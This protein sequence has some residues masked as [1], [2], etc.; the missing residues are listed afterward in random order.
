M[1][2]WSDSAT[3]PKRSFKYKLTLQGLG[4]ANGGFPSWVIKK[5]SRPTF[6][7]TEVA[8]SFLDKKYYFPGK[9]EWDPVQLTIAEPITPNST[10]ELYRY[11]FGAGYNVL[12]KQPVGA[13]DYST[14]GKSKAVIR[15]ATID[16]LNA[17]GQTIESWELKN[18][19][20]TNTTL[21]GLDYDTDAIMSFDM[22]LRFDWANFS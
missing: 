12:T 10:R 3:E 22:T 20:I 5:T 2:F 6:K 4:A 15:T 9:V 13:V 18:A 16:Q 1:A 11:L 17:D 21:T 8:H 7:I 19:F 14:I